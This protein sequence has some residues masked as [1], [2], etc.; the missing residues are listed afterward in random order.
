MALKIDICQICHQRAELM[1]Y[2]SREI[3]GE[4]MIVMNAGGVRKE[5]ESPLKAKPEHILPERV[6]PVDTYEDLE[7][8]T[9]LRIIQA[10][11]TKRWVVKFIAEVVAKK[12]LKFDWFTVIENKRWFSVLDLRRFAIELDPGL[13]TRETEGQIKE[14]QP[15]SEREQ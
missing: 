8:S 4:C 10:K 6:G 14:G 1:L 15:E 9:Y 5:G 12:I 2:D 13:E 11:H 7:R 3:C